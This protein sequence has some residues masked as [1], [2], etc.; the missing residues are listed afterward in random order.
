VEPP[1]WS[2]LRILV[3]RVSTLAL[4]ALAGGL[5]TAALVRISPGFLVDE[6]EL[7]PRLNAASRQSI[8]Q[9]HAAEKDILPFY[10]K[11][12][13]R[14]VLHGDLGDSPSLN[15]PISELFRERFPVTAQLMAIGI[16]GG[17]ALAFALALP[18]V[19][20]R[21]RVFRG[22]AGAFQQTLLCLPA[23]AMAILV[24][25][26][27]GPVRTLVALAISPRIFE[28]VRNL[29]AEAYAQPHIVTARAK[30]LGGGRIL[31]RHV[32]PSVGPPML[33]LAGVSVSMAF[34]AAIPVEALCDLPGI[35][36]LAWKAATARDLPLLVAITF[37]V[38]VMTQVSNTV[39]D[40]AG[41]HRRQA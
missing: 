31:L 8:E 36:Q 37:L 35:G 17:W 27:D 30:G 38:I 22:L 18:S 28:Y 23:A 24:F 33:A 9:E 19:I 20:C 4:T 10:W 34:A 32:L 39:S 1:P 2:Y 11:R 26:V 21:S 41:F 3:S 40:W 25:E 6:R 7:D 5:F 16:A 13:R 29:L 14:A 12:L 15:R